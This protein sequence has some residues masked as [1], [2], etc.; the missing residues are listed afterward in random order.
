MEDLFDSLKAELTQAAGTALQAEDFDRVQGLT[1]A[2]KELK[3]LRDSLMSLRDRVSSLLGGEPAAGPTQLV[4]DSEA[5]HEDREA[6]EAVERRVDPAQEVDAEYPRFYVSN[7]FLVKEALRG[8]KQT[9]YLQ[10][11]PWSHFERVVTLLREVLATKEEFH[12]SEV[13]GKSEVP[14]Y[15][16]YMTLHVVQKAGYLE[17]VKRGWYRFLRSEDGPWADGAWQS[18]PKN[19]G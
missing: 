13:V 12:A 16:A 10:R 2:A 8:D 18:I 4:G 1:E 7:D 11:M 9:K 19:K 15:Q 5:R 17:L 3:G 6:A 14:N